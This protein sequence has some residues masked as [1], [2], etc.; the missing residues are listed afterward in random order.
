MP[1]SYAAGSFYG[2]TFWSRYEFLCYRGGS[3]FK[4]GEH[5]EIALEHLVFVFTGA[6]WVSKNLLL[7]AVKR[8]LHNIKPKDIS[9]IITGSPGEDP[10]MLANFK[11]LLEKIFV[12]D[13]EKRMTVSQALSHPFITGKWTKMLNL[14]LKR[15]SWAWHMFIR[16][17]FI[18]IYL[19]IGH[20]SVL[21]IACSA[22]AQEHWTQLLRW[23]NCKRDDV[24]FG[25]LPTWRFIQLDVFCFDCKTTRRRRFYLL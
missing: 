13:P 8:L 18:F 22:L 20:L 14:W 15:C 7:Q 17:Y 21:F 9:V 1:L 5:I 3:C 10:K 23:I 19:M 12:L 2:S 11:D 25:D 4:E 6:L 24:W 16:I